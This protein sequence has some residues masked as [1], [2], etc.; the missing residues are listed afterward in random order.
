MSQVIVAIQMVYEQKFLH[1][2]NVPALLAVGLEG[3]FLPTACF[4]NKVQGICECSFLGTFGMIVLSI[5][6]VPMYFIH[7]PATFS[8]DPDGRLENALAAFHQMG[9][10][11]LILVALSGTIL[12]YSFLYR[13]AG[14]PRNFSKRSGTVSFTQIFEFFLSTSEMGSAALIQ[15]TMNFVLR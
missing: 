3:P 8:N 2:Y 10:N 11:P 9:E 6:L 7:V 1:K 14:R 13:Q 5:L 15:V 12:R 4:T